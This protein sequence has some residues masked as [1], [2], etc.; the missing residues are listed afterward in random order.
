M[1]NALIIEDEP[2]AVENLL[3]QLGE[4][5]PHIQPVATLQSI[6]D[7]IEWFQQLETEPENRRAQLEPDVIFMDIHLADGLVFRIFDQIQP[8]APII[9]TTAYDQYALQAF[10]VN[11]IDYLLKPIKQVELRRALEKLQ[12]LTPESPKPGNDAPTLNGVKLPQLMEMIQ[13]YYPH[14]KSHILVPLGAKLIP[15]AVEEIACCY[16]QNKVCV[17]ATSDGQKYSIDKSLDELMATM[18]PQKF[19][20]ANRQYIVSREAIKEINVGLFGKYLLILKVPATDPVV[21][22]KAKVSEFKEWFVI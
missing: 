2:L 19:F 3:R 15:L 8:T 5:A 1:K 13:N 18:N 21:I 11:S 4:V 16:L 9:F 10:K 22:P 17:I 12:K 7:T 20:R 14:Y 6:E